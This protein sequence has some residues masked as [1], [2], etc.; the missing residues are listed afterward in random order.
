MGTSFPP[1]SIVWAVLGHHPAWPARV[2]LPASA[3]AL[4]SRPSSEHAFVRFFGTHDHGWIPTASGLRLF[5]DDDAQT[6]SDDT[7]LESAIREAAEACAE[8]KP[9]PT[10][11]P[12]LKRRTVTHAAEARVGDVCVQLREFDGCDAVRGAAILEGF[13]ESSATVARFV[14]DELHLPLVGEVISPASFPPVAVLGSGIVGGGVR[15]FGDGRVCV[16]VSEF[17]VENGPIA[18]AIA[19]ALSDFAARHASRGI[20]CVEGVKEK[21]EL[22]EGAKPPTS[23]AELLE[24][25]SKVAASSNASP[26]AH[27]VTS[28]EEVASM[29]CAMGH[30]VMEEAN[31][32]GVTGAVLSQAMTSATPVTC[33]FSSFSPLVNDNRVLLSTV[34]ILAGVLSIPLDVTSLASRAEGLKVKLQQ[35][36]EDAHDG[37]TASDSASHMHMYS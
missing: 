28:D 7:M 32:T 37:T 2:I 12:V 21:L 35:A 20:F 19:T 31:V 16:I 36:L 13:A 6:K 27:F 11:V 26:H 5:T 4:S 3:A 34:P 10:R 33:L 9:P 25:V 1:G 29:L 23:E 30:G 14:I 18:H 22:P 24:A 17:K 15:I 8:K